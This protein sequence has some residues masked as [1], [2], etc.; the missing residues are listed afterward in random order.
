MTP[1]ENA[2]NELCAYT[3][4]HAL[5]DPAFI[6]QHVVDAYAAQHA[7]EHSKPIGVTF[8]LVGLF[9]HVEK[10][11]SGRRVQRV[12]IELGRS[13]RPWPRLPLPSERGAMT[14]AD[15]MAFPEGPERD[16]AID[17]WCASVWSAF[18]ESRQ[19]IIDLLAQHRIA[20]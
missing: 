12:H 9:L 19:S 15:V 1:D 16:R 3:L 11:A 14:A 20:G 4:G 5:R 17:D 10:Q 2:Y 8:A 13:K 18:A 7:D 6:H